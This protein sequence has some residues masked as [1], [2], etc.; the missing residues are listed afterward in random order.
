[1]SLRDGPYT[2][3]CSICYNGAVSTLIEIK[4][5][6]VALHVLGHSCR[7]IEK[8]LKAKFPKADIPNYGTINKWVRVRPTPPVRRLRNMYT[9]HRWW[10][11]ARMAAEIVAERMIAE[12]ENAPYDKIA[13]MYGRAV[14]MAIQAERLNNQDTSNQR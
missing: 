2:E 8:Q 7:N 13:L 12:L 3:P 14:D 11:V 6:A 1:V 10:E 5:E 4:A 9:V